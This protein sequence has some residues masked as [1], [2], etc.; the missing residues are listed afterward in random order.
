ME[1][2]ISQEE[3]AVESYIYAQRVCNCLLT[4]H[5]VVLHLWNDKPVFNDYSLFA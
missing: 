4:P 3:M 2:M 1:M 5:R